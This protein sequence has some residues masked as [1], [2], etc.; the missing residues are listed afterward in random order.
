MD[1]NAL[2]QYEV[3]CSAVQNSNII[4]L[5]FAGDILFVRERYYFAL[6]NSN[7][8]ALAN[9]LSTQKPPFSARSSLYTATP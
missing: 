2:R 9:L 7:M 3:R 1:Y 4:S 5:M 8:F 6:Q